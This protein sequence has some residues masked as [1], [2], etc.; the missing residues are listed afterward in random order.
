MTLLRDPDKLMRGFN[1]GGAVNSLYV[2]V[3]AD[4][5]ILRSGRYPQ[6]RALENAIRAEL[7][8]PAL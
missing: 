7:G 4:G 8:L 6:L 2:L 5:T 3:A 1:N